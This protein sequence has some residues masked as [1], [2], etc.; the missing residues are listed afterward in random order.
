M[1]YAVTCAKARSYSA[2]ASSSKVSSSA[3][4][5]SVFL[6]LVSG[7]KVRRFRSLKATR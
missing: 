5:A 2:A 4:R 7:Y 1:K 6:V 3:I